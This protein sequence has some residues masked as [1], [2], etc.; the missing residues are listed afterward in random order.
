M[1]AIQAE[2]WED[3]LPAVK[4]LNDARENL[5]APPTP[6][7]QFSQKC[8]DLWRAVEGITEQVNSHVEME[9]EAEELRG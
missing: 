4:K 1:A 3:L 6:N 7:D 2:K 9:R 8:N 5:P